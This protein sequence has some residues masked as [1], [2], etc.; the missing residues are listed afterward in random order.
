ME[1]IA[2]YGQLTRMQDLEGVEG[3][4]RKRLKEWPE[5]FDFLLSRMMRIF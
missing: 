1:E 2:H 3:E 4:Y 5:L